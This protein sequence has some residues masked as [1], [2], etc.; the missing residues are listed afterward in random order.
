MKIP[1]CLVPKYISEWLLVPLS[2]E[3]EDTIIPSILSKTVLKVVFVSRRNRRLN[4]TFYRY[5]ILCSYNRPFSIKKG[6]LF[7]KYVKTVLKQIVLFVSN[8]ESTWV[9]T[10]ISYFIVK[11]SHTIIFYKA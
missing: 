11:I 8:H 5:R 9:S 1:D 10:F 7:Q 2:C 3:E 4:A 6:N